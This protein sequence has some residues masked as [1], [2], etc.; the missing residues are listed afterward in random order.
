MQPIFVTP[1]ANI[2]KIHAMGDPATATAVRRSKSEIRG[3]LPCIMNGITDL[4]L[5][6]WF[7]LDQKFDS[8]PILL[9]IVP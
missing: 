2:Q 5:F 1:T 6:V 4:L 9:P 8:L 7:D 3:K